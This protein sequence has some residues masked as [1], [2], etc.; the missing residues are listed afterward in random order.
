MGRGTGGSS[1][2]SFLTGQMFQLANFS[3]SS[4][5]LLHKALP[6]KRIKNQEKQGPLKPKIHEVTRSHL[7]SLDIQHDFGNKHPGLL[8]QETKSAYKNLDFSQNPDG[9]A[10][11]WAKHQ[12]LPLHSVLH[13]IMWS[14]PTLLQKSNCS[15]QHKQQMVSY[16]YL[17]P[18]STWKPQTCRSITKFLSGKP[19]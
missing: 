15:Y 13:V 14:A 18:L 11:F 17:K 7:L 5:Q 1:P 10:E 8:C 12:W 3:I 2:K 9:W 4:F 19:W 16:P 6:Q